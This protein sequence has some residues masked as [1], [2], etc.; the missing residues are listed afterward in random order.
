MARVDLVSLIN[1]GP[2]VFG[3]E[4]GSVEVRGHSR[5][6]EADIHHGT[7]EVFVNKEAPDIAAVCVD[8]PRDSMPR[9]LVL[10]RVSTTRMIATFGSLSSNPIGGHLDAAFADLDIP[11]AYVFNGEIRRLD[12]EKASQFG[13]VAR[14][15]I[16]E[17]R[18]CLTGWGWNLAQDHEGR[19]PRCIMFPVITGFPERPSL[20]WDMIRR[21]NDGAHN[22]AEGGAPGTISRADGMGVPDATG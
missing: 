19:P 20:R 17:S 9:W 13:A 10:R 14:A 18:R 15:L 7:A 11:A 8:N 16:E 1:R 6:Q 5:I 2:V 12:F 22:P 3:A 4:P 21:T